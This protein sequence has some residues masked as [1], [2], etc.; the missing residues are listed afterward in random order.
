VKQIFCEFVETTAACGIGMK[1]DGT[2]T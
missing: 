2:S 1:T